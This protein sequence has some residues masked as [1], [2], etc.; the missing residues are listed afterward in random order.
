MK[1]QKTTTGLIIREPSTDIKRA[2]LQYFSL[3]KPIR[4][5]FIYSG[6]DPDH[7]PI[8]G[9]ERDVIYITSGFLK[10]NDSAI[11]KLKIDSTKEIPTPMKVEL[12]MNREP[13]SDLQRDCIQLLTTSDSNKITVELKPGTGKTFIALYSTAKLGL[14]PLIVA[15]TTLLKNQWIDNI[16]EL[17]IDKSDIA[18]KIWDA[19]D[20]KICVVTISSL[21]GALRDDWNGLLKTMDKASFGIKVV[22]EAHLHLKGMLKFDALCNIKHN[23]YMSATLG[24]SDA[25]EDRILN[26]ALLD[27]ERFIGNAAYE[28][29]QNEYVQVYLQDIYYFPSNRLCEQY[30]KYGSKGL[31]R[32]SYYN[33]LMNY[34]N[35]VPFINNIITMLKRAKSVINYDGKILLL[36]PLLSII[37]RVI[38]VMKQDPYFSKYTFAAV[39]GSM[40]LKERREAMESNF[41]LST[42]LSMGTGVDVSNLG[43][44]VNFDQYSSSIIG[45]QIFGRL[46]DRGKET[47][48][49]DVCDNVRQARMLVKWGQKRRILIPYY[50]GAKREMKRFPRIIS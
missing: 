33:M 28:E 13:R 11:K 14:K 46:R 47:Y 4:E 19:P 36:V 31:I 9:H 42:S 17:G 43:V 48:Y 5:F 25:S 39:D 24:R 20:K 3:Q 49:I 18:T 26:Y 50:P 45:E 6:N 22:D 8:L 15:P 44:V 10:I 1:V 34:R 32:S 40:P 16:V 23:W 7:K 21:E 2:C 30:F 41:I 35:G 37:K 27:A 12:T 38:E 29:Y